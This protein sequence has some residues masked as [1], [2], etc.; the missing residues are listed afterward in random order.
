MNFI[1]TVAQGA[2]KIAVGNRKVYYYRRNNAS[3]ATTQFN[4]ESIFNGEKALDIIERN[5]AFEDNYVKDMMLLHRCMYN[6]GAVVKIV[7]NGKKKEYGKDYVR[8]TCFNRKNIAKIIKSKYVP[9]YRKL[10]LTA[11]CISPEILAKFDIVRR[12]RIYRNSIGD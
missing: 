3:S 4:V 5:L 2:G 9:I 11:G 10:L 6:V 8:W 12:K 7:N 1:I